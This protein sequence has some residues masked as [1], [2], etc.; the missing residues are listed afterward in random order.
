MNK[1]LIFIANLLV[2]IGVANGAVRDGTAISRTKSDIKNHP[3]QTRTGTIVKRNTTPRTTTLVPRAIGTTN[4]RIAIPR[5][6]ASTARNTTSTI[7]RS[8]T[9]VRGGAVTPARNATPI[10]ARATDIASSTTMS[11]TRT[12]A[13]YE[14]CKNTY[15][16]CMDQFC[17]LKND[18]YRRCSCNDRVFKLASVRDTLEQAGEQLTVFTENLD[19]VGMT[20]AQAA[21][22][23]TESEG[24]SALTDDKSTSKALLQAI[25]NSIRGEDSN[26]GGKYADL[27]SINISFDTVNA[28][29][30]TDVGQAI[31]AYNGAALYNAVYPQC[32]D[33]V[34]ADCNDASLQRAIT[35]YLMA[36]EQDCNTVQ[37]A[38]EQTQ[39]QMKSAVREGSAMLDLARI[40]NRQKHNSSDITTCINEVESAILSEQVCGANY[41]KCLDN[42]EF[43]DVSTG[44]PIAGVENFYKL[45]QMLTFSDGIEAADQQLSKNSS[46]RTFVQ[47]FESRVKKFAQPALDKCVENANTVWAE[48]LDK[49]M[50][51][52]YYAQKSKVSEIKQG[53]FDYISACY[54]NG[55]TAITSAM[56]EL[57]G[58]NSVV[59][60]PDKVALNTQ[61]CADYVNSC[62]NMFDNNIIAQYIDNIKNTDTLT[63]C[64]A[65]VKQC[66]DKYGGTN[67]ENFYYP[68]SGLFKADSELAPDWF[69][70]HEITG[71]DDNGNPKY[72]PEYKSECAKQLQKIDACSD[73]DMITQAFGGF[74]KITALKG[75]GTYDREVKFF[76]PKT[77]PEAGLTTYTKYGL[78]STYSS[79]TDYSISGATEPIQG[80]ELRHR[81]TRPTGVATEVYNQI[82][83]VLSTQCMN[84]NGRFVELQNLHH[85]LYNDNN[86]CL[87]N[88]GDSTLT[89]LYG[90]GNGEDMC[91]RD[92]GLGVATKSWGACLCWENGGRRSKW[93]KSAKCVEM[94]PVQTDVFDATCD[95]GEMTLA[96]PTDKTFSEDAWCDTKTI[97]DMN[98]VCRPDYV[99]SVHTSTTGTEAQYTKYCTDGTGNDANILDNLPEGID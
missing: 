53:C 33:A 27:N 76:L 88:F 16:S 64:R 94:I 42:G 61:L 1:I 50:L 73:P 83:S 18:D 63:A 20:A 2:C 17:T 6:T 54:M 78:L 65:V 8:A 59:L 62:N 5:T 95:M 96:K 81:Y 92:Y 31:A 60:Q 40:E 35:A 48:Y 91:P 57:S 52:I 3:T 22:M 71:F 49:A 87:A 12:G 51:A 7:S 56:S 75:T 39:K 98:Q 34:R 32:R 37:T 46:N 41:H 38:V 13:E 19:V 43:I 70:L 30:M 58:I 82:I 24:E 55:D 11:S 72:A 21:A 29:G 25:M 84:L 67:Y 14:Q 97:S 47:N 86:L 99:T 85:D 66:F 93:G 26:V 69:T 44:K 80:Y 10:I 90:I 77:Q 23:R 68:Y 4:A 79:P 28:F 9:T 45:E 15:F 74:D 89:E 36:I